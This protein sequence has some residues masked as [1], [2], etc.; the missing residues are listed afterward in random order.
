M[1]LYLPRDLRHLNFYDTSLLRTRCASGGEEVGDGELHHLQEEPKS[2]LF[3]VLQ[4]GGLRKSA[5]LWVIFT[6]LWTLV[7]CVFHGDGIQTEAGDPWELTS[8]AL[9][10]LS[11]AFCA[12]AVFPVAVCILPY[13]WDTTGLWAPG[14][15]HTAPP[16]H[17][18]TGQHTEDAQM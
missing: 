2:S 3:R 12:L 9:A 7:S 10:I 15:W 6:R 5:S 4:H 11:L 13:V 1:G 8:P 17:A 16:P 18:H 14:G